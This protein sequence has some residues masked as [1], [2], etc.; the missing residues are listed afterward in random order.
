MKEH[1]CQY[2]AIC[3][4]CSSS[5]LALILFSWARTHAA[6]LQSFWSVH[7]K[8][9]F[10]ELQ[11]RWRRCFCIPNSQEIMTVRSRIFDWDEVAVLLYVAN[12]CIIFLQDLLFLPDNHGCSIMSTA[13]IIHSSIDE[14]VVSTDQVYIWQGSEGKIWKEWV[15]RKLF[16][17]VR[18]LYLMVETQSLKDM[19]LAIFLDQQLLPKWSHTC[20]PTYRKSLGLCSYV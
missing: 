14:A 12:A 11:K 2:V 17:R 9:F 8:L 6:C 20:R 19:S 1:P 18:R 3:S 13:M 16:C 4:S 10:A 7:T 5:T 15:L